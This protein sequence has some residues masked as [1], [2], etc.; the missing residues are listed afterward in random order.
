MQPFFSLFLSM[1]I[2]EKDIF[3]LR[4]EWFGNFIDKDM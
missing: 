3:I 1:P 4:W 2:A